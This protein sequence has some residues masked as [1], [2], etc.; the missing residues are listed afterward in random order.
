[1]ALY[2]PHHHRVIG[3]HEDDRNRFRRGGRRLRRLGASGRENQIEAETD[4]FSGGHREPFSIRADGA[5][6]DREFLPFAPSQLAPPVSER[7][8]ILVRPRRIGR[9]QNPDAINPPAL[10][11]APRD[12]LASER[13]GENGSE[14]SHEGATVHGFRSH[15]QRDVIAVA[16]TR[17]MR[18]GVATVGRRGQRNGVGRQD[19]RALEQLRCDGPLMLDWREVRNVTYCDYTP[20][21]IEYNRE[22]NAFAV[23]RADIYSITTRE[24]QSAQSVLGIVSRTRTIHVCRSGGGAGADEIYFPGNRYVRVG[25]LGRRVDCGP[26]LPSARQLLSS[27]G[28]ARRL[29]LDGGQRHRKHWRQRR[30]WNLGGRHDHRRSSE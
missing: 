25:D 18:G 8:V 21:T 3:N 23:A 19:V 12:G 5:L 13:R 24:G 30:G 17:A 14:A 27:R 26:S 11:C 2:E 4:Q 10:L 6:F 20:S 28:R 1:E 7:D 29:L 16:A 9:R 22:L 15:G